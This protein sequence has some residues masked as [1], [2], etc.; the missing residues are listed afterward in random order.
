MISNIVK[1]GAGTANRPVVGPLCLCCRSPLWL[2][3]A[4]Q[5]V[6]LLW[7]PCCCSQLWKPG[8][9][10]LFLI[11]SFTLAFTPFH[12]STPPLSQEQESLSW[13]WGET[14]ASK[15]MILFLNWPIQPIFLYLFKN[16]LLC[17]S[18]GL[19]VIGK[20]AWGDTEGG[21]EGWRCLCVCLLGCKT[22][23]KF[24]SFSLC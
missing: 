11:V 17:H 1:A 22:I 13:N 16:E 12:L 15:H 14:L 9:T 18:R 20:Q 24:A 23:K 2:A 19:S 8:C 4:H 6:A 7:S 10:G 3:L 5:A 21:R